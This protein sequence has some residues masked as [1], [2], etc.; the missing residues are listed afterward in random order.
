[1]E[2]KII[3]LEITNRVGYII[4]DRPKANC[5]EINFM[6]ELIHCVDEANSNEE[7]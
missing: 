5:Y 3:T 1:M 4:I 7:I 2:K 6:K